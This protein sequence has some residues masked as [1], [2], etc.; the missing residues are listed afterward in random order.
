[1]QAFHLRKKILGHLWL[2]SHPVDISA[3]NN[4]TVG[5][6]NFTFT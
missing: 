4:Q 2:Q 5:V 6:G 3:D 1:M